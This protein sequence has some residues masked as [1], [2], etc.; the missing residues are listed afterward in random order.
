MLVHNLLL[1]RQRAIKGSQ[2][3]W[4]NLGCEGQRIPMQTSPEGLLLLGAG[5]P[6]GAGRG[7]LWGLT[8]P[9]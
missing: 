6:A 7:W 1:K 3:S 9:R 5:M 4:C 2:E 8:S